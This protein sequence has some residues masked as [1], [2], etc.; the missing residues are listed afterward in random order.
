MRRYYFNFRSGDEISRDRIGMHLRDID[1]ARE[2]AIQTWRHLLSVA[3]QSGD[4]PFDCEIQ[5]AD[6]SGETLLTIP[7]GEQTTLH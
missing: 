2:E 7:F 3:A 5:I 1:A 4:P 6:D